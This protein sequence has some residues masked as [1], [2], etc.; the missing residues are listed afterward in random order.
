[1]ICVLAI[2]IFGGQ[3]KHF[4]PNLTFITFV[5]G[6][7]LFAPSSRVLTSH[8]FLAQPLFCMIYLSPS[9]ELWIAL[10]SPISALGK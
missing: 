6:L 9:Q 3:L 5:F 8:F 2:C 4:I 10:S 7:N 1:M